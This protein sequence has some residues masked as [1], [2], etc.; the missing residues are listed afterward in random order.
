MLP[1]LRTAWAWGQRIVLR[2][3][4][5]YLHTTEQDVAHA[6]AVLNQQSG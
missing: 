6:W 1:A 4:V 5:G 2:L 3:A